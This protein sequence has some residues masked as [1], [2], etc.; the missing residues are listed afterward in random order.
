MTDPQ[1]V[2]TEEA[3]GGGGLRGSL[4]VPGIVFLVVAAAAPLTVVAGALPVALAIGNGP[5]VP[6]AYLLVALALLLFSVGYA[7]MSRHV[8]DAGAFY[9]YVTRG[10]G[11]TTGLGT[12][13]LAL[14]TYTSV[15]LAVYGLAGAVLGGIVAG[16][17]GPDL[18]WWLWCG[19]LMAIIGFLGYR[20]IDVGKR[21]LAVVLVLEIGIVVAL[22]AGVLVRGGPEG[23]SFVSFTPGAFAV[24]APGIA[25][26]FAVASFIGFEATAIYGEEAR[27][28]KSTVPLATYTAVV[29]IGVFYAVSSWAVV[30]AY[31]PGAVQEAASADIDGLVIT[32]MATYLG[33]PAAPIAE[34]LLLGSMFAALIA[35]HNAIAR[36]LYS[37]ARQGV[38]PNRL[39]R[40]HPRHGSPYM[41]SLAQTASAAVIVT[42][43]ALAGADPVLQLFT[44][45]SG[46]AVVGVLGLMLLTSL[47]VLA[48]FQRTGADRRIWHTRIAPVL[49]TLA[50]LALLAL[51]LSNFTI[52]ID[53]SAQ[54]AGVLLALMA[55]AFVAGLAV[56]RLRPERRGS[57]ED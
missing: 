53:G 35:F 57:A 8:V 46:T 10:L 49:G 21:V 6:T 38:A 56:A 18:P 2:T 37:L 28:P 14:V 16:Y 24:G 31:G 13:G 12:A 17:G 50:L 51:V 40:A 41:G 43:F 32:A 25:V 1:P 55:A 33:A 23:L 39:S 4:G 42:L 27:R 48:F 54:L 7:A 5:G 29:I 36:Y 34:I 44:W 15:Q 22:I 45:M 26:M 3:S 20:N 11:R 19:V 47:A 52:L 30:T 9:A